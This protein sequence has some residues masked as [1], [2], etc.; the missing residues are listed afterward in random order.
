MTMIVIMRAIFVITANVVMSAIPLKQ[1]L[2]RILNTLHA[3]LLGLTKTNIHADAPPHL[4][5]KDIVV[6]RQEH[7]RLQPKD[8]VKMMM[9][10]RMP[11]FVTA[12]FAKKS[13]TLLHQ[14][15][16]RIRNILTALPVLLVK[17]TILAVVPN[18]LAETDIYVILPE[19]VY[20]QDVPKTAIAVR[21]KT[22]MTA[23]A[24]VHA[25]LVRVPILNTRRAMKFIIIHGMIMIEMPDISANVPLLHAAADINAKQHTLGLRM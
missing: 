18:R 3:V 21:M 17:T 1:I 19:N 15:R 10:A 6:A 4:A 2:V 5:G 12:A 23:Y 13:V 16:V 11:N 7:V 9:I 24:K 22:V 20:R 25:T 14:I 8:N